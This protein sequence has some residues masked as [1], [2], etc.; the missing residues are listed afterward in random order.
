MLGS[1]RYGFVQMKVFE[2]TKWTLDSKGQGNPWVSDGR[3]IAVTFYDQLMLAANNVVLYRPSGGGGMPGNSVFYH[4]ICVSLG[5]AIPR[6][7]RGQ[8]PVHL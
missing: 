8:D 1:R 5:A 7:S 2:V 3:S 6:N 4:N